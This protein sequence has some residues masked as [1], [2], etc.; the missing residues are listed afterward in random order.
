M[1]SVIS[2]R[3]KSKREEG[4]RSQSTD[5]TETLIVLFLSD[6]E[7][8]FFGSILRVNFQKYFKTKTTFVP[9]QSNPSEDCHL[10][11]I[12]PCFPCF[13]C[14]KKSPVAGRRKPWT[15]GA[16]QRDSRKYDDAEARVIRC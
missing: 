1:L 5:T 2:V 16:R 13:P 3:N 8:V 10:K 7:L 14:D 4:R 9:E 15:T 11:E 12:F 6:D